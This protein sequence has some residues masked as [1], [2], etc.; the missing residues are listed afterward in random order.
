[1]VLRPKKL[2]ATKTPWAAWFAVNSAR[3]GMTATALL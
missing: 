1:M 2:V 3:V